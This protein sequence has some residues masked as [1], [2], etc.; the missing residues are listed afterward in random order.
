MYLLGR[1][2]GGRRGVSEVFEGGDGDGDGNGG[3][4]G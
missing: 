3:T 1:L 2:P 4:G